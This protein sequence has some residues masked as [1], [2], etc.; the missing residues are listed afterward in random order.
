MR[1]TPDGP[2][3]YMLLPKTSLKPSSAM[4]FSHR[5]AMLSEDRVSNSR[6]DTTVDDA[7][8]PFYSS[9]HPALPCSGLSRISGGFCTPLEPEWLQVVELAAA[10]GKGLAE[11]E[12]AL[13]LQVR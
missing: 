3:A 12:E 9:F 1:R 4:Q 11:L 6:S 10:K 8:V 13:M 5:C 7:V 2:Q